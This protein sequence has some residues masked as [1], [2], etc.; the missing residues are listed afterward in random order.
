MKERCIL[1]SCNLILTMLIISLSHLSLIISFGPWFSAS[2][3]SGN[4]HQK[5]K[6]KRE[7]E[8]KNQTVVVDEK[9]L[10]FIPCFL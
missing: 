9:L 4:S 5:K 6:Y 7:R 8:K 10:V 1:E 2:K 3:S